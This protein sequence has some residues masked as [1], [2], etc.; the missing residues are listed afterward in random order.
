MD[1][2]TVISNSLFNSLAQGKDLTSMLAGVETACGCPCSIIDMHM[3]CLGDSPSA[4]D[5]RLVSIL[6]KYLPDW[7]GSMQG[8]EL[9]RFM[10]GKLC[11]VLTYSEGS[12]L[13][14]Q[15]SVRAGITHGLVAVEAKE[16]QRDIAQKAAKLISQVYVSYYLNVREAALG[17]DSLRSSLANTL[18][19]EGKRVDTLFNTAYGIDFSDMFDLHGSYVMLDIHL[20]ESVALLSTLRKTA[21]M[22]ERAFPDAYCVISNSSVCAILCRLDEKAEPVFA[23]LDEFMKRECLSCGASIPFCDLSQRYKYKQQA[24]IAWELA[25]ELRSSVGLHRADEMISNIIVHDMCQSLG[26]DVLILSDIVA[27]SR[28]DEQKRTNYLKTLSAWLEND[29]HISATAR[30]LF[31]DRSTLNYRLQKIE[32]LLSFDLNSES[33]LRSLKLSL[34]AWRLSE[35]NAVKN[36]DSARLPGA[37]SGGPGTP[38]APV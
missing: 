6:L 28:L 32:S 25:G 23:E 31:L 13:M 36:A 5:N 9:R 4:G 27:L 22:L 7:I 33:S 26:S 12:C 29:C 16:A 11:G 38:R 37:F 2:L 3:N 30:C 35:S 1:K 14:L 15:C 18:L 24:R 19:H 10:S 8:A 17:A 21:E 34:L 20:T